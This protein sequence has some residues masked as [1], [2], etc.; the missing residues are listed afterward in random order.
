MFKSMYSGQSDSES[1]RNFDWIKHLRFEISS[2]A[3]GENRKRIG[4]KV[5]TFFNL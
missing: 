1:S 4:M 5:K 3:S 2:Q